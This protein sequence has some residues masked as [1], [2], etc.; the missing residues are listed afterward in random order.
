MYEILVVFLFETKFNFSFIIANANK[1]LETIQ[2]ELKFKTKES[3][4]QQDEI[5][6]LFN[7]V[8]L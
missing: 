7:Q 6:T 1:K 5:T 4:Q 8:S 2:E 3:A